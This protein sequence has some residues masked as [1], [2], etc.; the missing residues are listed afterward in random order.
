[1]H[2]GVYQKQRRP[3]NVRIFE[4]KKEA[5]DGKEATHARPCPP[6]HFLEPAGK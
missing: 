6:A 4:R 1:M 3:W 2:N 5:G